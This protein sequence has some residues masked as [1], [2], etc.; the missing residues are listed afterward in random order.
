MFGRLMVQI[1]AETLDALSFFGGFPQT[2]QANAR[3]VL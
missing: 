2:F 1:S 3:I